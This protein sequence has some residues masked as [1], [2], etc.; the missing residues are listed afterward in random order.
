MRINYKD[1]Y[2]IDYA[3]VRQKNWYEGVEMDLEIEDTRFWC[4]EQLFICKYIYQKMDKVRP[5]HPLDI[6]TLAEKDHF[7]VDVWVTRQMGLH[8]LMRLKHDYNIPL[9][10]Q[11]Y[12]TPCF[13]EG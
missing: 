3:A 1:M 7:Q 8:K 2:S 10:R 6:D 5:M 12:S 13:Q 4:T 9:I 11:F